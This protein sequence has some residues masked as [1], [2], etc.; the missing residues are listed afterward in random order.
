MMKYMIMIL[1]LLGTCVARGQEEKGFHIQGNLGG[2]LSGKLMLIVNG[3]QG[4]VKLGETDMVNGL[5]EFSG[6][7]D[8]L[9][10]AY[11]LTEKQQPVATLMLENREF[12]LKAG[13]NGI[14]IEGGEQ[15]AIWNE[16]ETISR[17]V[18]RKQTL[19]E[20]QMKAAYASQNQLELESLQ[21]D[22]EE[23]MELAQKKREILLKTHSNSPAAACFLAISMEQFDYEPLQ[24]TYDLLGGTAKSSLFGQ[25]IS[26]RLKDL[27][28]LEPG[29]TAP[30]FK[31]VT[32]NGDTVTL[33]GI[34]A[35]VK[36]LDFWASWCAPCR[37]ENPNMRKIYAKY[38]GA[39]LEIIGVSL[40][41]KKQDWAHAIRDDKLTWVQVSDLM[42][43]SPTAVLYNVK[44]IP[45]TYLL[46]ENN[47][48]VARNLRGKE[49]QKKIAELL[50][51]K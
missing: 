42:Q 18:M 51:M 37:A 32:L 45:C 25:A 10:L 21:K 8:S 43:A 16:F 30:D 27:K 39:G 4:A 33:Y 38:H 50:G 28:R 47:R 12:T 40:D 6:K 48:V 36:L 7:V 41:T 34:D 15:Q 24:K 20:P 26:Q 17:E 49:L 35:K 29:G 9:M 31:A 19:L 1:F 2:S 14:D 22:Y 23:F 13:A 5:F 11:I 46:D 3:S 44:A